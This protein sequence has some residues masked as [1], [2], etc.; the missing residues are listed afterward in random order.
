M[1]WNKEKWQGFIR[2][3]LTAAGPV[4]AYLGW[5][6]EGTWEMIAGSVMTLVGFVWSWMAP[7][8]KV[9]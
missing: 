2:H 1:E 3:M 4:V 6:D 7:E 8:K 9:V 5:T